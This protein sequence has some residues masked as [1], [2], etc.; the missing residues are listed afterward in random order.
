MELPF[1]PPS[2]PGK[3]PGS[4]V[5]Q[6]SRSFALRLIDISLPVIGKYWEGEIKPGENTKFTKKKA[7]DKSGL[8]KHLQNVQRW[9]RLDE[10]LSSHN[11][12][13]RRLICEAIAEAL[14]SLMPVDDA[15]P[16][17][18]FTLQIMFCLEAGFFS[19]SREIYDG[20]LSRSFAEFLQFLMPFGV[21]T[22]YTTCISFRNAMPILVLIKNSPY[23]KHVHLY[24][25]LSNH[26]LTQLRKY[27]PN[28]ESITL[29]GHNVVSEEYLFRAFFGGKDKTQVISCVECREKLKLSF[30]KLKSV[31]MLMDLDN[32]D[33]M[34][35]LQ[36]YYPNI[37]TSW[38][39]SIAENRLT[40][41]TLKT[42]L[43][44]PPRLLEHGY[45][46][47][48]DTL[49]FTMRRHTLENWIVDEE[50][51]EYPKVKHVSI[52]HACHD[53]SEQKEIKEKIKDVVER[54]GCTT[55]SYSSPPAEDYL[56][57]LSVSIPVLETLGTCLTEA[58]L[59]T[60]E[61]LDARILFNCLD[62]CPGLTIFS[63]NASRI[64][65]D[66]G[67]PIVGLNKL[68]HLHSLGMSVKTLNNSEK[69]CLD[70]MVR[71]APNL[72][73][74]EL[75]GANLQSV[76]QD[77]VISGALSKIQ[78]LS[79][80]KSMSWFT[81]HDLQNCIFLGENLCSL[82]VLMLNPILRQTLFQIKT[83]FIHTQL[84]VIHRYKML[85]G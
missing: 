42:V 72:K 6:A 48:F 17:F 10:Y 13:I 61:V 83:H 62:L 16:L 14:P 3:T 81:D 36:H 75:F 50:H 23:L 58:H 39:K 32:D 49:E 9:Y 8:V 30:P 43:N 38:T 56:D 33:I 74:V 55:F 22:I 12:E 66:S 80:H 47:E 11:S 19:Q 25:N 28:I 4:L 77:L 84:K 59:S 60:F 20:R 34:F 29:S 82:S 44:P 7:P 54:L 41:P 57:T 73:T 18:M 63:I 15:E 71:A 76:V 2:T 45:Y 27:C 5:K 70:Y 67:L 65:M 26:V 21:E 69:S 52:F 31:N 79:L 78:I 1:D 37:K 53:L 68:P 35:F 40:P 85:I 46:Y 24:R 64:Q 51:I